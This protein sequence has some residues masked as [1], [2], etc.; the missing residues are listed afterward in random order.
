MKWHANETLGHETETLDFLPET[1][2]RPLLN[3]PRPTPGDRD[4]IPAFR[5]SEYFKWRCNL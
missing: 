2:L 1:R 4:H 3:F 5:R